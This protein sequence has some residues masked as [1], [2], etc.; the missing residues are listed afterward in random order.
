MLCCQCSHEKVTGTRNPAYTESSDIT[1]IRVAL[2]SYCEWQTPTIAST[3]PV[4]VEKVD[5]QLQLN[6]LR[7]MLVG[8]RMKKAFTTG[9][10]RNKV[11]TLYGGTVA[12]VVN[13]SK[14]I[15]RPQ[16]VAKIDYDDD[17]SEELSCDELIKV[18][19]P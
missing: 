2:P 8:K 15:S 10:G 1:S 5:V 9:C 18:S 7:G 14:D 19:V 11:T 16:F 3:R 6:S 13:I 4:L 17:D 12:A